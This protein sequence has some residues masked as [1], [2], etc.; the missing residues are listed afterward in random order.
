MHN[1]G[2]VFQAYALQQYLCLNNTVQIIDYRPKYLYT[3]NS[4][5]RYLLK[6]LLFNRAYTHRRDKFNAF[7]NKYMCLTSHRYHNEKELDNSNL[8]ADIYITGSDQLWNTDYP[9][10]NDNAF[11]LKFV[12][13]G[14]KASYSTSVGKKTIDLSNMSVLK[15][16]L[17][18]FDRLSVREKSTATLLSKELNQ[19]VSW[20][21]DPVF[22]LPNNYYYRFIKATRPYDM[23][24]VMVYMSSASDTLSDIVDYYHNMGYSIVLVGGFTKRCQC[25]YHDKEVG[26]EDFLN[27]IYYADLVISSSFHA[28]AFCHIFHKDFITLNPKPNGE[29]IES[30]L[31]LT[32]LMNRIVLNDVQ[33]ELLTQPI[34]W[35]SVDIRLFKHIEDSKQYLDS[36]IGE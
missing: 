23:P 13:K 22:L 36:V 16:N 32:G 17:A 30:L 19:K 25:D 9:C 11:Y 3:E 10:G 34:D 1:P 21:C 35:N 15:R 24:Y 4:K 2:S 28:T 26:P 7:I 29:R 33:M 14:I 20:V 8:S 18:D 27:Y 12:N 6:L 31:A 5:I